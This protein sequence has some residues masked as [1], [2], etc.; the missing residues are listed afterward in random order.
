[1]KVVMTVI[2]VI[3]ILILFGTMLGGISEAETDLRTDSFAAVV[4]GGGITD[5]DVVLV[6]DLYDNSILNVDS[7]TS[8]LGTDVPLVNTYTAITNTL[9]IHGLTASETRTLTV[10]YKY[11]ALTG[12]KEPVGTFLGFL[13][14]LVIIA[15]VVIVIAVLVVAFKNR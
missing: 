13:P 3:V 6:T 14:T 15:V 1:M 7:I 11:D 9:H 12:D 8:D 10:I 4:T 2:G 5:A